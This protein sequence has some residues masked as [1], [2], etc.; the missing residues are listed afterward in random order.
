M[1]LSETQKKILLYI[2]EYALERGYAPSIRDVAEACGLAS[3]ASVTYQ[4]RRLETMGYLH[5][6]PNIPRGMVLLT[7]KR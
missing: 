5:R 1:R 6:D 2:Q 7:V 3:T 4:L